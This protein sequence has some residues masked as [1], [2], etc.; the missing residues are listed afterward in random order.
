MYLKK[1]LKKL[2][3]KR[4]KIPEDIEAAVEIILKELNESGSC[5]G[6]RLMWNRLKYTYQIKIKRDTVLRILQIVDPD[7]IEARSKYRLKR[8]LYRVPGPN[9][10]WHIDG[11]DKLKPFGFAIHGCIDGYSRK[12]IW[13]I[14]ASSNKNP[15][16]V[17]FYY[18][19]A[20]KKLKHVPCVVRT[21]CG[22]ENVGIIAIQETLRSGHEDEYAG[23]N[24]IIQGKSTSNQRIESYWGRMRKHGVHFWINLFKD[25]RSINFI[26]DSN[27]W[28][29]EFTRYCF[30]PLIAY[31]LQIIQKEHN[32]HDI[33]KQ[34]EN[35]VAYGKPNIMYYAPE[36]YGSEDYK[37]FV[38]MEQIEYGL[39]NWC[40][41]SSIC[42]PETLELVELLMPN[43]NTPTSVEE[44]I[45]LYDN[46]INKFQEIVSDNE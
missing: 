46:L 9:F 41:E 20:I 34:K 31:D 40:K 22:T 32:H 30:G 12:V 16:F 10:I 17:S 35:N 28:K 27:E 7:G 39:E 15:D 42:S 14:L 26:N 3:L 8:R 13:L 11:Y 33:R 21:D 4:H 29:V 2:G 38:P 36:K 23:S 1:K 43:H 6:Y 18:L 37:I 44:A 45:I 19:K 5:L 24:S 25:L